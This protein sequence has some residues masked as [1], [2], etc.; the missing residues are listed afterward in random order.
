MAQTPLKVFVRKK[1]H[2]ASQH[3]QKKVKQASKQFAPNAGQKTADRIPTNRILNSPRVIY[4]QNQ[5]KK[6]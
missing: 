4:E 3:W 2:T 1:D 6:V 5:I